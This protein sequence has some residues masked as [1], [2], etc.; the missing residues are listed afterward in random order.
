ML[1][2]KYNHIICGFCE[3]LFLLFT[4]NIYASND[5]RDKIH[6]DDLEPIYKSDVENIT[7]LMEQNYGKKV[8]T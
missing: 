5:K 2:S 1:K 3:C 8:L 6:K 4:S 7:E